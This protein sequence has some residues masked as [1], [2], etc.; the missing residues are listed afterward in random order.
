MSA[1]PQLVRLPSS[2]ILTYMADKLIQLKILKV[3]TA[4]KLCNTIG[5]SQLRR[6]GNAS[7]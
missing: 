4:R 1:L 7:I 5:E 2:I 6:A 3:V